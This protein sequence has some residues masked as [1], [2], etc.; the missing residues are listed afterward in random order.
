M[1]DLTV[2]M[3]INSFAQSYTL[4]HKMEQTLE[5]LF[6]KDLKTLWRSPPLD[7]SFYTR[8][9]GPYWMY[10]AKSLEKCVEAVYIQNPK[11]PRLRRPDEATGK[12]K[13]S[14]E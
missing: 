13:S 7:R 9:Y 3:C 1:I 8:I 5:K 6:T 14:S 10:Y 2:G 4:Y 11:L 12:R